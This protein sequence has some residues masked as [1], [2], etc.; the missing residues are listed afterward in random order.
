[1]SWA[2]ANQAVAPT[3]G[4]VGR[5]REQR[6]INQL[7]QTARDGAGGVL[8]LHGDPGVGK[9]ALLGYAVEIGEGFQVAQ[10]AGV[11]MEMELPFAGV[12]QLCSP[13]LGLSHHLPQPQR[14]A[15][16][17]AFG[18]DTGPT[19]DPFF[20]G[21]AVVGLLS[22]TAE[23]RPLLAVIDDAQWLDHESARAV[24][25][26]ARRLP[27]ASIAVVLAARQVDRSLKGL[28]DLPIMP[29]ADP[30]ARALL[31]A[32][33]PARIDG[34]VLERIVVEARGNPLALLELP[35]G[36]TPAQLAGGFG[37]PAVPLPLAIEKSFTRQLARLPDDARRLLLV[38]AADATGDPRLLERAAENLEVPESTLQLLEAEGLLQVGARAVFR[39]PLLRSAVYGSATPDARRDAHRALAQAIDPQID[40]DHRAWQAAQA[41]LMPDEAIAADLER[42]A[43]RA[44]V[45]GGSGAVDAFLERAAALTPDPA[46]RAQRLLAA[47]GAKRDAGD[48]DGAL[49]LLL[50]I[51]D[52]LL[53]ETERARVDLLQAQVA[54]EQRRA[55][56]AGRLFLQAATRLERA[57]P[58]LARETYLEALGGVLAGDIKV[59]GGAPAVAAA[60]RAA[61]SGRLP[62]RPADVLLDAFATRLTDGYAAAVPAYAR[63]LEL[64]L[65]MDVSDDDAV[66][67][68]SISGARNANIVALELWDDRAL[69]LLAD[70]RAQATRDIGA[71][72]HLHF[73]LSFLA[74]TQML[75]GE[76]ADAAQVLDEAQS[77]A[78]ATRNP[79]LVS[80]PIVLAAWRGQDLQA[81]AL[82]DAGSQEA[83][84]RGWIS[85]HYAKSVLYNGLG[86]HDLARDAAQEAFKLDPIGYGTFLLPELAEAASRAGDLALLENASTWL[87]QRTDVLTSKWASGIE[88]RVRAFLSEGEAADHLY[89]QSIDHLAATSVR[90][91]LARAHLLYGEWLR[92]DRRRSDAREQLRTAVE[93]FTS[94][95]V[96]AFANRAERELLATGERPRKRTAET[97]DDLTPQETQVALLAANGR[98]NRE[99]AA[100]L[101]I[102]PSTVDYHL[103]KVFRKLGINSRTQLA[104]RLD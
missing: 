88:A 71:L 9:T 74:R 61:P 67:W 10:T 60:A 57:D 13:F 22:R 7:L 25:L 15:L 20:V 66:Q 81:S 90:L 70:T 80:A 4:L 18:L 48:Q 93:K 77:I 50:S 5:R 58:Q 12:Q 54:L 101:F 44:R 41:A 26:L 21:L 87:S 64:L 95:G 30:D 11:E 82:T 34:G 97:R 17:V 8:V 103:R 14:Q 42:S 59:I 100:Q 16:D 76:F 55:T 49:E 6:A 102:S 35:R 51:D 68:L 27:A 104:G 3:R 63:A 40:A 83:A 31:E 32:S 45:R 78:N 79:Q 43:G 62:S 23:E 85:Y 72:G 89:R 98:R 19:P 46:R 96:E 99:I 75:A 53:N 94:M 2:S 52:Q 86:H 84:R 24:A 38:A 29:L 1:M 69:H 73:A 56:D 91:E 33:L 92:R 65:A 47:A 39:H 37:L 36:R 28:P